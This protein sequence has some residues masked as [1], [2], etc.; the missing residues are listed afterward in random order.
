MQQ[1]GAFSFFGLR[2]I[3]FLVY[4]S[5]SWA[6]GTPSYLALKSDEVNMRVGPGKNYPITWV[7]KRKYLPMRVLATFKEWHKVKAHD[8]SI[9]W[10]H[11]NMFTK[12]NHVLIDM[13]ART[14]HEKPSQDAPIVAN[15][16]KYNIARCSSCANGWCKIKISTDDKGTL[17]GY[18]ADRNLWGV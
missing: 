16:G 7:F 3:L 4:C 5:S 15:I 11:Q 2:A 9:G 18:I 14:L 6:H 13:T 17:K 10:I 1:W 8:G 12:T